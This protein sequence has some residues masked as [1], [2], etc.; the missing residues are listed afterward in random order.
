MRLEEVGNAN[1]NPQDNPETQ[2][3]LSTYLNRIEELTFENQQ[4]RE[5]QHNNIGANGGSGNEQQLTQQIQQ[6]QLQMQQQNGYLDQLQVEVQNKNEL[7]HQLQQQ[8]Q[9][10]REG[11]G[12][13]F[14]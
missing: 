13:F 4:L 5:M 3:L 6:L 10:A 14:T 2:E 8:L 1:A 11:L 7:V 9:S 12:K